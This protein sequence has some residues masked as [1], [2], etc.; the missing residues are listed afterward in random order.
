M[1]WG[2]RGKLPSANAE[3]SRG[4]GKA[5]TKRSTRN[6]KSPSPHLERNATCS[7]AL[8]LRRLGAERRRT[9][10][11]HRQSP[12]VFIRSCHDHASTL[13][14]HKQ[15]PFWHLLQAP[16]RRRH[17]RRRRC[18]QRRHPCFGWVVFAEGFVCGGRCGSAGCVKL[19]SE[20]F[21]RPLPRASTHTGLHPALLL[22]THMRRKRDLCGHG[23]PGLLAAGGAVGHPA[24]QVGT[25]A[26]APEQ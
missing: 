7:T 21:E 17:A 19:C 22:H 2:K 11:G 10:G 15:P 16:P 6:G 12:R 24:Q 18:R 8:G 4:A 1:D 14:A 25:G 26:A 20:R 3:Q 9:S 13:L 23:G 5:G